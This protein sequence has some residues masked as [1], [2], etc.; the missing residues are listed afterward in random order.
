MFDIR[1]QV[2]LS[3]AVAPQRVS[4]DYPRRVLQALQ[5]PSEEALG[6]IGVSPFLN[7]DIKHNAILIGGAPEIVLNA[8]DSD[9]HLVEVPLVP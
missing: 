3:G 1:K 7:K 6:G 2:A 9:E 5:Q 4:H 8:L